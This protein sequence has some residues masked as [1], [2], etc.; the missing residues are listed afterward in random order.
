MS[1][2]QKI[3][4]FSE[5]LEIKV[6]SDDKAEL[7]NA[8]KSIVGKLI[9]GYNIQEVQTCYLWDGKIESKPNYVASTIV[10]DDKKQ[11]VIDFLYNLMKAKWETPLIKICTYYVNDEFSAYLTESHQKF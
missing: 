10:N 3:G 2:E 6:V 9:T 5:V 1:L 4:G 11:P 8:L 7:E